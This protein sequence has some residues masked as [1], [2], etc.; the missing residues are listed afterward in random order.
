MTVGEKA[1]LVL[2]PDY[3]YGESG[4]GASIPPNASL[5]FKVEL[6]QIGKGKKASRYCKSDA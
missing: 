4:A 1:E 3:A 2:A 6:I 5:I